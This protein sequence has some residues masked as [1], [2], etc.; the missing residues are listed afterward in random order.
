LEQFRALNPAVGDRLVRACRPI[1][2]ERRPDGRLLL[3]LGC[4][5]PADRAWLGE[6]DTIQILERG[7]KQILE[8]RIE[9]LV[10]GWP[11]G[12]GEPDAPPDPL[13]GLSEELR[14]VGL[15]CGG[16]INRAFFAATARRGLI[17]EC[18]FPILN[19]R[20]DFA[21][22]SHRVG[23]EIEGWNWRSWAR[24]GAAERREREQ[25]LGYEGWSI[26]WFSGDEI[27]R[28]LDRS[29]DEVARLVASR[30]RRNGAYPE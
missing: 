15:R 23:V 7:L 13:A 16:S 10:T 3:V 26:L 20:L 30:R 9:V 6:P 29:V 12:D 19:Y 11:A 17:F 22:P 18:H 21:L 4:W 25:S 2:A 8:E 27:L 14:A 28:H 24:P 1:G 5:V